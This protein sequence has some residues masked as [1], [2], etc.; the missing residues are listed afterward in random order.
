[1][2]KER[3]RPAEFPTELVYALFRE[4]WAREDADA[5]AAGGDAAYANR[6]FDASAKPD[7]VERAAKLIR[8]FVEEATRRA[9]A[10]ARIECE[11]AVDAS[12]LE[13]ILPQLLLDFAG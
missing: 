8:A 1:M 4:R 3:P 12:H 7:A 9:C 5:D 6:E 11:R 10:V 2:T 13:R